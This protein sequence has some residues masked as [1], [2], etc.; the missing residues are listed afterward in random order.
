[1]AAIEAWTAKITI[2]ST[3]ATTAK[4]D[5]RDE[6]EQEGHPEQPPPLAR[7]SRP[8]PRRCVRRAA[9]RRGRG[10]VRDHPGHEEQ[11]DRLELG[12]DDERPEGATRPTEL[13]VGDGRRRWGRSAAVEAP[14]S[15]VTTGSTIATAETST[16]APTV[17]FG[18]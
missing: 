10:H 5:H 13:A 12:A 1:M 2:S 3:A 11:A 4:D 8:R 15:A 18:L 16:A 9:D 17:A 7:G 14:A 6:A